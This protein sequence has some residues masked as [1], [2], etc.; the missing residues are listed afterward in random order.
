MTKKGYF[1]DTRLLEALEYID[2]NLVGEVAVKLKFDEAPVLTEEPTVT[3]RT[4]FKHWKRMLATVACLLL[5]SAA[6]PIINYVLPRVGINIGGNAG[7]G[8]SEI[9]IPTPTENEFLETEPEMT[10][11]LETEPTT[12]DAE[13]LDSGFDKYLEAFADMSADE[14]Y[15]EVLKGGW[16]VIQDTNCE[17][18]VAIELW[19]EFLNAV[20]Q[21]KESSILIAYYSDHVTI[22]FVGADDE[23]YAGLS[24]IVLTEVK[25]DGNIF[26]KSTKWF[27]PDYKGFYSNEYSYLLTESHKHKAAT[28]YYLANK[29]DQS[30]NDI[31]YSSERVSMESAII[32][33]DGL[34]TV[35]DH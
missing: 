14:I 29:P 27:H 11:T 7:A 23:Q 12:T 13:I 21:G 25:Y 24:Q 35:W 31:R 16:V 34:I 33:D 28:T 8:T 1:K 17:N 9:E 20:E 3:W 19:T 26:V 30:L 18:I 4:P 10:Q 2:R 6:L 5:L 22:K 32:L 15:A